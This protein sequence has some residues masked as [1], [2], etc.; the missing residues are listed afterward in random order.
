M[1][2][3]LAVM[4]F[5]GLLAG[6]AAPPL[7]AVSGVSGPSDATFLADAVADLI[8]VRL[9]ADQG[10]IT[11]APSAAPQSV[12]SREVSEALLRALKDR[13]YSLAAPGAETRHVV[14]YSILPLDTAMIVIVSVDDLDVSRSYARTPTGVLVAMSPPMSEVAEAKP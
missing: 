8:A 9:P 4:A 13:Q 2:T 5:A 6:C 14:S 12:S 11:L 3:N 7:S 1:K 10:A